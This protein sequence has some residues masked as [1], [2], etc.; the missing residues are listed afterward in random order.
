VGILNVTTGMTTAPIMNAS[1]DQLAEIQ[2]S[3][4]GN[5]A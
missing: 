3:I 5:P 2:P 1:S 4:P